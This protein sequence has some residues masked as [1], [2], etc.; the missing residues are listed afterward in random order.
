MKFTFGHKLDRTWTKKI[1]ESEIRFNIDGLFRENNLV[2]AFPQRDLHLDT[3]KPLEI[4]LINS[5][6]DKV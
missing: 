1:L 4:K 5:T 6:S 2:I 3:L